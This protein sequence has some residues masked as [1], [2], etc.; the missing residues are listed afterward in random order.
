MKPSA[1]FG[2]GI[3]GTG[4]I[5]RG[6]ARDAATHAEIQLL[7]V[8]DVDT[9]RATTFA[10]EHGVRVEPTLDDLLANDE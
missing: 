6:Y 3:V 5:A 4:N 1:P 8:T 9:D 10:A 7:A 2:L